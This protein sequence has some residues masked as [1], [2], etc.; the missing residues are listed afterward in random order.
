M[1]ESARSAR[2]PIR[3]P[4]PRACGSSSPLPANLQSRAELVGERTPMSSRVHFGPRL[5]TRRSMRCTATGSS[6][7][8]PTIGRFGRARAIGKNRAAGLPAE[9][10]L[11]FQDAG[12]RPATMCPSC[13]RSRTSSPGPD[14]D[15]VQ[16]APA[17]PADPGSPRSRPCRSRPRGPPARTRGNASSTDSFVFCQTGFE[18]PCHPAKAPSPSWSPPTRTNVFLPNFAAEGRWRGE[19]A[20]LSRRCHRLPWARRGRSV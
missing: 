17:S 11:S 7:S 15:R 20:Y 8:P 13:G 14:A 3:A 18:A 5:S 12:R 6:R 4:T 16:P 19:M 1:V 2:W 9:V 10:R